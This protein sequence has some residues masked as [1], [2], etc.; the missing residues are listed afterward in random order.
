[1]NFPTANQ[2]KLS[3]TIFAT[4]IDH[5]QRNLYNLWYAPQFSTIPRI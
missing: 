5:F 3:K 2:L 1:V 4:E